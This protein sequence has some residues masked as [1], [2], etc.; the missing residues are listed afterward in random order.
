MYGKYKHTVRVR[1]QFC[2]DGGGDIELQGYCEGWVLLMLTVWG[3]VQRP[4]IGLK[5]GV[6][7][8]VHGG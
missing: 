6:R 1:I 3:Q 8:G 7:K 5:L 2:C 4:G